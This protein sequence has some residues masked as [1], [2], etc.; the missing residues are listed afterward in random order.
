MPDEELRV[1]VYIEDAYALLDAEFLRRRTTLEAWLGGN[2]ANSKLLD[3]VVVDMVSEPVL[4]GISRGLKSA[5]SSTAHQSDSALWNKPSDAWGGVS[6]E[7]RH[8]KMLGLTTGALPRWNFPSAS[9][10]A[11]VMPRGWRNRHDSCS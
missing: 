5:T 6:L 8:L 9:C 4:V 2:E 7:D 10:P 11:E 1:E 3:L